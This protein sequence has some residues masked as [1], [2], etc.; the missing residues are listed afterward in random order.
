M[1]AVWNLDLVQGLVTGPLD[2][3]W[4]LFAPDVEVGALRHRHRPDVI[5]REASRMADCE[6]AKT[7]RRIFKF[8]A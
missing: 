4:N 7:T 6:S 8:I 2:A 5:T 1:P 3:L